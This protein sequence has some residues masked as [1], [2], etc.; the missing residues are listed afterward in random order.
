MNLWHKKMVA[1]LIIGI[2][3]GVLSGIP[4]GSYITVKAVAEVGAHFLDAEIVEQA[5]WQYKNNIAGCY[6]L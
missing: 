1:C 6:P 3:L 2:L 5:I 4:V